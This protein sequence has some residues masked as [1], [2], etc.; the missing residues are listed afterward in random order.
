MIGERM[1]QKKKETENPSVLSPEKDETGDKHEDMAM[2]ES[3]NNSGI[4]CRE[5]DNSTDDSIEDDNEK[6]A[7]PEMLINR[8][9]KSH[10]NATARE[11]NDV[12]N[13]ASE[14][15]VSDE[16]NE[17]H[18]SAEVDNGT[19]SFVINRK[20]VTFDRFQI[21]IF[22]KKYLV[23]R[24]CAVLVNGSDGTNFN[25]HKLVGYRGDKGNNKGI[26]SCSCNDSTTCQMKKKKW[27]CFNICPNERF[28]CKYF[29]G[30]P[31]QICLYIGEHD[32]QIVRDGFLNLETVNDLDAAELD[33][34]EL[35]SSISKDIYNEEDEEMFDD[36]Q[37][38]DDEESETVDVE[39]SVKLN[40]Y[41]EKI[42][43]RCILNFDD[44]E[45]IF[46]KHNDIIAD[47]NKVYIVKRKAHEKISSISRDG[48]LYQSNTSRKQMPNILDNQSYCYS[49]QCNGKL[50]CYNTECPVLNRLTVLNS[51]QYKK[52]SSNICRFCTCELQWEECGG[53]KYVLRS[54]ETE[55]NKN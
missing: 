21:V 4:E 29:A 8:D 34:S 47:T 10:K 41:E 24:S 17:N 36:Y 15:S 49:Y 6:D 9:V 52:T 31:L 39:I 44:K 40:S 43:K 26:T 11:C 27:T 33:E 50:V 30:S 48:Y 46:A 20:P 51:F 35:S 42:H 2:D 14:K 23:E 22:S 28:C 16:V 25:S 19:I 5:N 18:K 32:H 38:S 54:Q 12:V 13:D 7:A 55:A 37:I 45:V 1:Y 3:F 53:Q